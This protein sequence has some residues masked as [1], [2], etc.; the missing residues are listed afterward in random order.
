MGW[1]WG[2]SAPPFGS[3][4]QKALF[5]G[6]ASRPGRQR[7]FDAFGT[8]HH[9]FPAAGSGLYRHFRLGLGR[10]DVFDERTNRPPFFVYFKIRAGPQNHPHHRWSGER[11]LWAFFGLSDWGC[12]KVVFVDNK[13][14]TYEILNELTEETLSGF[15]EESFLSVGEVWT[16][17]EYRV[18]SVADSTARLFNER[19]LAPLGVAL[20]LFPDGE[21]NFLPVPKS[22]LIDPFEFSVGRIPFSKETLLQIVHQFMRPQE[23]NFTIDSSVLR[24]YGEPDNIIYYH[25]FYEPEDKKTYSLAFPIILKRRVKQTEVEWFRT[26]YD[27]I[28]SKM[29]RQFGDEIENMVKKCLGPTTKFYQTHSPDNDGVY[30]T[31]HAPGWIRFSEIQLHAEHLWLKIVAPQNLTPK[32]VRIVID[33]NGVEWSQDQRVEE[34]KFPVTSE[35]KLPTAPKKIQIKLICKDLVLDKKQIINRGLL[36][37]RIKLLKKIRN[38]DIDGQIRNLEEKPKE[39]EKINSG[40]PNH[41]EQLVLD[42]FTTLGFTCFFTGRQ[43][44]MAD[45]VAF[46]ENEMGLLECYVIECSE[47]PKES[48]ELKT[49]FAR[50]KILGREIGCKVQPV[51]ITS[52][53]R[54]D[55]KD[56][57]DFAKIVLLASDDIAELN[58]M[59]KRNEPLIK[60]K[61]YLELKIVPPRDY[62]IDP[63]LAQQPELEISVYLEYERFVR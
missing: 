41:L 14:M 10:R 27:S 25:H 54:E 35:L 50:T 32:S 23:R 63:V 1:G 24:L 16:T 30:L 48:E 13:R 28:E 52:V 37:S 3:N 8:G 15:F 53:L 57:K 62:D 43:S 59:S 47:T 12:G 7:R 21:T 58:E 51:F 39:R 6:S 2:T 45:I 42:L 56:Q 20:Y 9:F 40:T 18:F 22:L 61:E 11:L 33:S 31:I 17:I 5:R 44:D 46:L 4:R 29:K 26:C 38:L 55:I 36:N 34:A 19:L 49:F 60:A